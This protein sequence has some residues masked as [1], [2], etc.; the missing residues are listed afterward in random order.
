MLY[1]LREHP[2]L[3]FIAWEEKDIL[4]PFTFKSA[5]CTFPRSTRKGGGWGW[6]GFLS[7]PLIFSHRVKKRYYVYDSWN[8]IISF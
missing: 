2:V 8:K 5:C 6:T 1:I 7:V 3:L 4:T